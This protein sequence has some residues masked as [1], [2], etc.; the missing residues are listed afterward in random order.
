MSSL[1]YLP[2][3]PYR[4]RYTELSSCVDGWFHKAFARNFS[5]KILVP[6]DAGSSEIRNGKVLDRH[7]RCQW[8]LQQTS[9]L[10]SMDSD[11]DTSP[12]YFDDFFHPGLEAVAYNGIH[13]RRKCYSFCWAQT[14]D[15]YDF[16][17]A[18]DIL[19]WMR[20][21][22]EM[23]MEVYSRVFVASP[24]LKD[25]ILTAMPHLDEQRICV[26]GLPFDSD[27][28]VNRADVRTPREIFDIVYSSRLDEEK[29]PHVFL[30]MV[31]IGTA[32]ENP[33][34]FAIC[35][36]HTELRGLP[37][38]VERAERLEKD[39]KLTILRGL[40]KPE[41]YSVLVSARAQVNTGKQDW[42][43]FTLLEALSFNCIPLY[44]MHRDFTHVFRHAPHYLYEPDNAESA[45]SAFDVLWAAQQDERDPALSQILDIH[46]L[47]LAKI[48]DTIKADVQAGIE[49]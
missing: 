49:E 19:P 35:T 4:A 45:L 1:T 32:R 30:D 18:P 31:E 7:E 48:A 5:T 21:F 38:A 39:G 6:S 22:E 26:V 3:E 15:Q 40:T 20:K 25:L 29:S 10:L 44:P 41:Y 16:T 23:A 27:D 36:G 14:F 17:R 43:S 2:L 8:A 37:S 42:V 24:I 34:K 46:D 9:L 13:L 12:I 11:A 47:A 28:V 33:L